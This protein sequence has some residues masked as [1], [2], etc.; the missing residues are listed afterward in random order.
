MDSQPLFEDEKSVIHSESEMGSPEKK[1]DYSEDHQDW[2]NSSDTSSDIPD[3][4]M[5]NE[6]L[7][8]GKDAL[9][10]SLQK[11]D[12]FE[13]LLYTM[14]LQKLR[15]NPTLAMVIYKKKTSF[16]YRLFFIRG[17]SRETFH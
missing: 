17:S 16:I 7:Y 13:G 15:D 4:N 1:S 9:P 10:K 6:P 2:Y 12:I 3:P 14:T 11:N 5:E 8:Q